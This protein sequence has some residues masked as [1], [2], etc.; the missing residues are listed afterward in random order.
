MVVLREGASG[1]QV[2]LLRRH[3][4][5]AVL[6]GA[7]VFPGGKLERGDSSPATQARLDAPVAALH[8]ALGEA[9][10]TPDMAAGLFV[11]ALR[12]ALEE[13]GVLLATQTGR[14]LDAASWLYV[15]DS[16]NDQRMFE[17][18]PLSVAVANIARFVPQLA[19]LPRYVTQGERGAGFT[20][21]ADALLRARAGA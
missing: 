10:L 16:A 8:A 11:A 5:S 15:G 12:E 20:E 13:S 19:H 14:P 17:Q 9:A 2:L 3:A 21:L 4:Q 18:L 6:G 7:Y 1:P